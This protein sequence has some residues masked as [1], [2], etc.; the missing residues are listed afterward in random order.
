M[1][2][3]TRVDLYVDPVC[4]FAWLAFRWLLEVERERE[5]DLH[6]RLMSLAVLNEGREGHTPEADK[7]LDSAWRPVRVGTALVERR[8]EPVLRDYVWEF[9]HRFHDRGERGRD[10]VLR[11]VLTELDADDLYPAADSGE[12]DEIVRRVHHEG[13]DPVGDEVGTPVLHVGGTAF[14]GPVL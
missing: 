12:L 6:V 1:S 3:P 9:G 4:P 11:A 5:L 7:G 14:F 2:G 13:M 10:D 8:G